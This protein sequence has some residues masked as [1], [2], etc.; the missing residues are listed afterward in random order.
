M[1]VTF[2]R[3]GQSAAAATGDFSQRNAPLSAKGRE[4]A[5]ALGGHFDVVLCSP[6]CRA[7]QT[8]R[9]SRISYDELVI[10][11]EA[12]EVICCRCDVMTEDEDDECPETDEASLRRCVALFNRVCAMQKRSVLIISHCLLIAEFTNAFSEAS[13][14]LRNAEMVCVRLVNKASLG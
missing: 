5:A 8:L 6:L 3:A 1:E 13:L 7:R 11:P 2:V 10:A 12:R 9:L 4:E 14:N